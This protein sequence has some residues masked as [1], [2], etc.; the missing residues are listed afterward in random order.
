MAE[1]VQAWRQSGWA[2]DR[3]SGQRE[4]RGRLVFWAV[5]FR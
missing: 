3:L 2:R 5:G 1:V 4:E